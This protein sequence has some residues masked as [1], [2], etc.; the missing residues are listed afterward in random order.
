MQHFRRVFAIAMADK[1]LRGARMKLRRSTA[2]IA[3]TSGRKGT[4]LWTV[5]RSPPR[6]EDMPGA[7]DGDVV[8]F[9]CG[10]AF[11]RRGILHAI[12][13]AEFLKLLNL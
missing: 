13:T 5:M 10:E 3:L 8:A 6:R 7:L 1:R 4:G 12:Y 11:G 2:R 9:S